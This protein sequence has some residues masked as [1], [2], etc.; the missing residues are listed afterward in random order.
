LQASEFVMIH[1]AEGTN[2]PPA[3]L[4]ASSSRHSLQADPCIPVDYKESPGC[5]YTLANCVAR[6]RSNLRFDVDMLS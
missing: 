4:S 3:K 2:A 6:T 1:V 5:N